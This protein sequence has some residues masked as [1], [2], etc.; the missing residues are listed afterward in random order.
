[1]NKNDFLNQYFISRNKLLK[2]ILV[3]LISIF[4]ISTFLSN[5]KNNEVIIGKIKIEGLIKDKFYLLEEIKKIEDNKNIQ[6]LLVIVNS[7]GGTFVSSKEIFNAIDKISNNIP[8]AVYMREVATSGAYLASLGA[9]Q[10]FLNEATITGS[11]GVILQTV[12]FTDLFKMVGINP[13]V[14]KSGELKAVPNPL[15]KINDEKLEYINDIVGQMQKEFLRIVKEKRNITEETVQ[16]I[17]DGRIFTG[18]IAKS[19]NLVDEVGVE[20]DAITW[21][22]KK[23][24][25]DDN[26]KV[27]DFDGE[28][29][30]FKFLNLKIIEKIKK[31]ELSLNDGILAVWVPGL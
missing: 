24:N 13:L 5:F 20:D 7:P 10:I 19:L 30:I 18:L 21:I 1:M 23:G 9:N 2:I 16:M 11:V 27:I 3:L 22:K 6:G 4:I 26:V 28:D 15:E 12:E 14:V 29:N 31:L 17:S 25:L 8:T